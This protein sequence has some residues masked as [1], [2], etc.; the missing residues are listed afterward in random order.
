MAD[1]EAPDWCQARFRYSSPRSP[2]T[3]TLRPGS[4]QA[5]PNAL[6][7]PCSLEL[8]DSAKDVELEFAGRGG[9]VDALGQRDER[10]SQRLQLLEEQDQMA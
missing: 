10:N 9:R 6:R 2:Q 8:R 5:G 7:N 3:L 1:A 4:L